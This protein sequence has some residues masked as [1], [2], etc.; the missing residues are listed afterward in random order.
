[1]RFAFEFDAAAAGYDFPVPIFVI[2]GRDDMGTPPEAARAFVNQVRAP[3]K[4]YTTLHHHRRRSF[5]VF[6]QTYGLPECTAQRFA[7]AGAHVNQNCWRVSEWAGTV[8]RCDPQKLD[9]GPPSF[10]RVAV[11]L[12]AE[13]QGNPDYPHQSSPCSRFTFPDFDDVAV[14]ITDVAACLANLVLRLGEELR[15]STSP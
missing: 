12:I 10:F 13:L 9:P 3:A 5:R 1:M 11:H 7:Y 6:H 2:Q 14:W 15:S 8:V 4:N